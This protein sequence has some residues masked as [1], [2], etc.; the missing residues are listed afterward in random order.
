MNSIS[1]GTLRTLTNHYKEHGC[2]PR[3]LRY[4][5]RNNQAITF[6]EAKRIVMFINSTA[7]IHALAL[8]G[9]VPGMKKFVGTGNGIDRLT[10][11]WHTTKLHFITMLIL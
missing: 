11:C 2:I 9:R 6:E 8:P 4:K 3:E 5:G 1:S 7:S 10:Q